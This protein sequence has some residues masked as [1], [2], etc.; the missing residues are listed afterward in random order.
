MTPEKTNA[1]LATALCLRYMNLHES[2][3]RRELIVKFK[4]PQ[5]L[6]E[7]EQHSLCRSQD[8]QKLF[9]PTLG[10]FA[11]LSDEHLVEQAKVGTLRVIHTLKNLFEIDERAEPYS[12]SDLEMHAQKLYDNEVGTDAMKLG[13]YLSVDLGALGSYKRSD[14][15]I[16]IES[17][18]IP[19]HILS[20]ENPDELWSSRVAG[21]RRQA[22]GQPFV[23]MPAE[24]NFP[25]GDTDE[26]VIEG[27][28][29]WY[30]R[31]SDRMKQKTSRCPFAQ[32]DLCPRYYQSLTLSGEL[33][34]TEMDSSDALRL[35]KKWNEAPPF[36]VLREQLPSVQR[37][38]REFSSLDNFCPEVAYDLQGVFATMLGR[39]VDET[40]RDF[41]HRRLSRQDA[42]HTDPAW[43]WGFVAPLHYTSCPTF[44]VLAGRASGHHN[45][46][47]E[48]LDALMGLPGVDKKYIAQQI[49]RMSSSVSKD[50][51]LA[52]GTAKEVVETCCK[53]ILNAL[54]K[55]AEMSPKLPSLVKAT[56]QL[57]LDSGRLAPITGESGRAIFGALGTLVGGIAELRNVHGTGHGQAHGNDKIGVRQA[58]LAVGAAATICIYLATSSV[59]DIPA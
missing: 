29:D 47:N 45:M 25:V 56:V 9:F 13:L 44:S 39:Y 4:N 38:D 26:T 31:E 49:E 53:T 15:G 58:R 7:M 54:G 14:D 30:F 46:H 6:S 48:L 17:F 20:F 43:A 32:P 10:S 1:A 28:K 21:A 52:I 18:T 8:N 41:A 19:E 16:N 37:A 35:E 11:L 34:A 51:A 55:S 59:E 3:R 12:F 40:D 5:I 57:L 42:P 36:A 22:N 24:V 2:T 33:G 23:M 50:P 27:T